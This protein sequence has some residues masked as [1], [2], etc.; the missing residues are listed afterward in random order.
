MLNLFD[1]E[2]VE[3]P[4][5]PEDLTRELPGDG[6]KLR[7]DMAPQVLSLS[8]GEEFTWCEEEPLAPTCDS[9][10][11]FVSASMLAVKAKLFDDGM[12]AA[13]ELATQ[14][15]KARLLSA[16]ASMAP[17]IAAAARLGGSD[18]PLSE[19]ARSISTDF[20]AN[21]R[22]SKPLGFYTWSDS[23]RRIFQQDRLLQQELDPEEVVALVSALNADPTLATAYGNHLDLVAKLTNPFV[24]E[25]PDLRRPDGRWFFPASRSH[26]S[27][28]TNRLYGDRPIP[29]GFSLADELVAQLISGGI[30]L[31]PTPESGWYDLQ[32]WA[33]E[34][35]VL[36]DRMPESAK[37]ATNHEYRAELRNVFKAVIAL[38]RETHVKQVH[39]PC[40][41]MACPGERPKIVPVSPAL[42]VEPIRSYYLRRA[43]GYEFVR[44]VLERVA[45]LKT[46]RRVTADGPARRPLD[47]ELDDMITLFG[48]AA[49]VAGYEIGLSPVTGSQLN[50]F[51]SWAKAPDIRHDI[52]MMVPVFYDVERK[53]TKV[54]AV[55]GWTTRYL[56]AKFKTPPGVTFLRGSGRVEF[57]GDSYP[58]AAPVFAETY[59]GRLLD[60]NEFRAHCDRY[61]TKER[62]LQSL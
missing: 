42:S 34:P 58:V 43:E 53:R 26:E 23:L 59:V 50:S 29:E 12:Y 14:P 44:K 2:N 6:W 62:I 21:E 19:A 5:P 40:P 36:L 24:E 13:V 30:T 39:T 56:T 10:T 20:L 7:I 48:D 45:P 25:T 3:P 33:L 52:R 57:K 31:N 17:R 9:H 11:H 55:L 51:R 18:T 4:P 46:M 47:E 37:V 8:M 22:E 32:T 28:L 27:T 38:T 60:R 41:G 61:K 16:L 54:W 35:L 49:A 1:R 15:G